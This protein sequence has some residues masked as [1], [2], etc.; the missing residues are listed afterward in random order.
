MI[1]LTALPMSDRKSNHEILSDKNALKKPHND[2]L[3]FM[4][5]I[6]NPQTAT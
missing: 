1:I 5:L 6:T 2:F 4:L 3:F